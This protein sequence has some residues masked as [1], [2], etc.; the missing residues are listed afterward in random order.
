[1]RLFTKPAFLLLFVSFII[2]C[3]KEPVYNPQIPG[4]I[5]TAQYNAQVATDWMN[6]YR[7]IVQDQSV[8]P[9]QAARLYAYAGVAL[10]ES[11]LSGMPGNRSFQG[12]L[13]GLAVDVMP[14]DTQLLDPGVAANEALYLLA[15]TITTLTP[16]S[17]L[18]ADSLHAQF[19]RTVTSDSATVAH[20]KQHG[21]QVADAVVAW[22]ATDNFQSTRGMTAA[23]TLPSRTGHP[24]YWLPTDS[25]HKK[26][27]EPYWGQIRPFA[28]SSSNQFDAAPSV[29]FSEDSSSSF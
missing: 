2:S 5:Q 6:L 10:Y 21:A 26:P 9:P 18:L 22:A 1:M 24:E 8:N 4:Q 17:T 27:V 25:A 16:N 23:Y 13:N 28:L 20:S 3:K 19:L 14:A 7:T 12:Q 15:K 11:V 29:P